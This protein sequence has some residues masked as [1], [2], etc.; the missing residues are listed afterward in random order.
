MLVYYL[1]GALFRVKL[2]ALGFIKWH[3]QRNEQ[4]QDHS[5]TL[6]SEVVDLTNNL[7]EQN[8]VHGRYYE[9]I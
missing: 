1:M 5:M 7:K 2:L 4:G 9:C 8:H 3:A 6:R